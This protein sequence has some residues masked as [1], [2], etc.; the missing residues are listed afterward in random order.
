M[1][2]AIL[3]CLIGFTFICFSCKKDEVNENNNGEINDENSN[4]DC[5]YENNNISQTL[6]CSVQ[7]E[8]ESIFFETTSNDTRI[9]TVNNIPSHSVGKFP[10]NS[11]PHSIS[12]QNETIE[13][14]INPQEALNSTPLQ[15]SNGPE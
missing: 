7:L 14:D 1:K 8:I 3:S 5:S 9:F 13:I 2:S 15:T 6:D 12:A 11:N 4:I 10:N